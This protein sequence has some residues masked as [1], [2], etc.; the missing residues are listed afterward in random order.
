MRTNITQTYRNLKRYQQIVLVLIK[1]GFDDI[2]SRLKFEFYIKLRKTIIPRYKKIDLKRVTAAHRL[3][4]A[5]QE[6]GPTFIK[7]GQILSVRPDL[8]PIDMVEEFQKLQDEVPSFPIE[9]VHQIIRAQLGQ[10]TSKLFIHFNEQPIA[11][12]SI[13]QAHHAITLNG[14]EVVVKIQRPDIS[15][16]IETDI[17]ILYELA[18]LI[19]RYIPENE[20]YEPSQIVAEFAKTIRNE[21]D[22]I[23]E[24]RNI[25]R[26]SRN[27]EG[28]SMVYIPKV[29]WE[30]TSLKILTMEYIKGI[31]AS[32]ISELD[33]AGLD[34]KVIA[35][36]GGV[37][38]LEQV[39][40]HGFFHADPHPGNIFILK[41]NVIAPIDYG[42]MG[43]IDQEL[44]LA[45]GELLAAVI[46]KDAHR[47]LR[48]FENLN[49]IQG[50]I[51]ERALR[52][53][54][55]DFLERYYHI[56]L[57]QL[58]MRR[59]IN[60]FLEIIKRYRIRL[61]ADLTMM[62]KALIITEGV[63][64]QLDPEFDFIELT[65]P[66]VKKLLLR[67]LDPRIYLRDFVDTIDDFAHL[68]RIFPSETKSI[69]QKI[70]RG[71][72][73]I[74]FEH[75]RLENLIRDI[76]KASNRLSFSLIIAAIIV[77]SSMIVQLDK[78]PLLFGFPV[79]GIIGYIIAGLLGLWLVV[80]IIRSGNL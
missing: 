70:K 25:D 47:I 17:S 77:G 64:R 20:I 23:R 3:R 67:K 49:I 71:Q 33:K 8:I 27:F 79:I 58:E 80:A 46:K 48:V 31:K 44:R 63:G 54:L 13:A 28:N 4:L 37:C 6:L 76:D 68:I 30:L 42:I 56:P 36:N 21:L 69:L 16:L 32:N 53:E 12:A 38:S 73:T 34:R 45:L 1:Y 7:L 50:E 14:Q 39:F 72:L 18:S 51:D 10:P 40:I 22:F 35:Y 2:I 5:M 60:E 52:T 74:K 29:Y 41:D 65:T 43:T 62:A 75:Q 61:P 11:A 19:E 26:F 9:Q 55:N 57:I 78:G 66:Y 59:L 15:R 24:G